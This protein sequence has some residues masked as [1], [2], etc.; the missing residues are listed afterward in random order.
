A[1]AFN[2]TRFA[3]QAVNVAEGV[4]T[5]ANSAVLTYTEAKMN[6]LDVYNQ[7]KQDAIDQGRTLDDAENIAASAADRAEKIN[8]ANVLLNLTGASM[9]AKGLGGVS[10]LER[11]IAKKTGGTITSYT[12]PK[13]AKKAMSFLNDLDSAPSKITSVNNT[14]KH[15]GL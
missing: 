14:L 9:I 3:N 6:S 8:M 5:L 10:K 13:I 11:E 15:A 7:V 2:A 4:A 12:S 1:N